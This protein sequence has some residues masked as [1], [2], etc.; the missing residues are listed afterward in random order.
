MENNFSDSNNHNVD[1]LSS[2]ELAAIII[3][4]LLRAGIVK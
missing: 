2:E 1:K 3:D 4:A